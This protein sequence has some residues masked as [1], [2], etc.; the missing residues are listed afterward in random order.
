MFKLLICR[1]EQNLL[2][3]FST[4]S[5]VFMSSMLTQKQKEFYYLFQAMIDSTNKFLTIVD[6]CIDLSPKS[7]ALASV[8]KACFQALTQG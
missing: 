3:E 7:Q 8:C 2:F 5:K 4:F 1:Y 6:R